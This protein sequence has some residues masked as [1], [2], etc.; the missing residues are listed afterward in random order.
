MKKYMYIMTRF[1]IDR[2][3]AVVAILFDSEL[4]DSVFFSDLIDIIQTN[5]VETP[6]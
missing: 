1:Y 3:A 4:F 5:F 2:S 6:R